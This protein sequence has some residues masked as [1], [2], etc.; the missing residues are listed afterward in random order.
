MVYLPSDRFCESSAASPPPLRS[1]A[2]G[3]FREKTYTWPV[4]LGSATA[5]EMSVSRLLRGSPSAP[6]GKRWGG[7]RLTSVR[8]THGARVLRYTLQWVERAGVSHRGPSARATSALAASGQRS[9][10]S[11]QRQS[12][13][14]THFHPTT[15]LAGAARLNKKGRIN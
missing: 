8:A 10:S 5:P 6:P 7:V 11:G 15:R 13:A 3:M 14:S 9:I 12:R 2:F 4:G 1:Q